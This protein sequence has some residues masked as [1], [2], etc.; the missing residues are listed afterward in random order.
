MWHCSAAGCS[1]AHC[2][3][4]CSAWWRWWGSCSSSPSTCKLI[5][6]L[7]PLESGLALVPSLAAMIAAGLIVVPISARVSPRVVIPAALVF[8]AAGYVG[9]ALTTGPHTLWPTILASISLGIGVGAAETVSN[10]L[11]LSSAPAAKA[12]AASAVSETA[13]ELGTVL[14]TSV[15]GGLLTAVYRG[16]LAVPA[17]VPAA[18]ADAARETLAGAVHA[19]SGLPGAVGAALHEA[20]ATA[21]DAG[22]GAAA[23]IG[24]ALVVAAGVIA[25][26]TLGGNQNSVE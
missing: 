14:G 15:I 19:A 21:F 18:V 26:T 25:A 4:T 6:G 11:I 1:P 24:A 20:A 16:T 3:S 23:L 9:I 22:V 2:W 7:S 5:V 13:Y 17:G 12:G 10:E 8:S